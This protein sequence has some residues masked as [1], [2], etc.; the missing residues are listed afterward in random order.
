MG[1][2]Q[3]WSGVGV[4]SGVLVEAGGPHDFAGECLCSLQFGTWWMRWLALVVSGF[5]GA[6]GTGPRPGAFSF[7]RLNVWARARLAFGRIWL[8]GRW[9]SWPLAGDVDAA[10]VTPN[11]EKWNES[12]E[13]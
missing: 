6:G 12:K 10:V 7:S 5:E 3:G 2:G 13:R 8:F 4:G 11:G 9:L 1:G